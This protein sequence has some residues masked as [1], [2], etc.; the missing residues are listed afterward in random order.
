MMMILIAIFNIPDVTIHHDL[1]HHGQKGPSC[2]FL[3]KVI[4]IIVITIIILIIILLTVAKRSPAGC[5]G[6]AG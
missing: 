5:L 1:P 2:F 6:K 4:I 3:V